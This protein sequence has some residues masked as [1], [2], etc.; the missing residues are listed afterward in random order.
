M[1]VAILGLCSKIDPKLQNTPFIRLHSKFCKISKYIGLEFHLIK[2]CAVYLVCFRHQNRLMK[3][4]VSSAMNYRNLLNSICKHAFMNCHSVFELIM[5]E[6][7]NYGLCCVT[8]VFINGIAE[9][10]RIKLFLILLSVKH[11]CW[12]IIGNISIKCIIK[13]TA[14]NFKICL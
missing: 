8:S 14:E 2:E 10:T 5:W 6:L 9:L 13:E 1:Y 12:I 11:F 3:E 4:T 7:S